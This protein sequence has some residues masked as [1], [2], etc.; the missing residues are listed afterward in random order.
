M[1]DPADLSNL[2]DILVPPPISWWPLAPGW[3]IVAAA[4]LG[5]LAI[6]ATAL[7]RH[8]Q[9]NA[10]RSAALDELTAIAGTEDPAARIRAVSAILKRAALV[11]YPRVEVASLT[12][13]S[14]LAF[15]DRTAGISSFSEGAGAALQGIASGAPIGDAETILAAARHWV[16]HHRVAG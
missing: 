16:K 12:G 6:L 3:W 13:S 5:A 9:R 11:A 14:W 4:L 15:L 8:H 7:I 10:Y 1:G 2:R